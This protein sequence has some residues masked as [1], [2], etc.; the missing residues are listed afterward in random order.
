MN[1]DIQNNVK[2]LSVTVSK[3]SDGSFAILLV[4]KNGKKLGSCDP[5]SVV[6]LGER[7]YI[8]LGH[9]SETTAVIAKDFVKQM[10]FGDSGDYETS[11][12][13]KFCNGEFLNELAAAVGLDNIITHT[14]SL[15][16][17]D[18]TGKGKTCKDKVSILT[19]ENYR[20]YRE[21]LPGYGDWWWTATRVSYDDSIGYSR[22]VCCVNSIG[23]LGWGGCGYCRGVRPFCILNSSILV[24]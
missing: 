15:V 20:R 4:E 18:G 12:V 10:T 24:S 9:G 23:V 3:N 19:A 2:D 22:R 7:E 8:V 21:Y 17:D 11:D 14:V 1:I 16:A 5:G 6:K 13:R